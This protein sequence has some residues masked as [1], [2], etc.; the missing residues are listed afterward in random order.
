MDRNTFGIYKIT[1]TANGKVYIG[2]TTTSFSQRWLQ[3][4]SNLRCNS[5]CNPQLQADWN[6]FGE[7]SFLFE[8]L[9]Q[10]KDKETIYQYEQS[11]INRYDA[12]GQELYNVIHCVSAYQGSG[13]T[14][15]VVLADAAEDAYN[16]IKDQFPFAADSLLIR[17]ALIVASQASSEELHHACIEAQSIRPGRPKNG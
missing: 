13:I 9:E 5:H 6:D 15:Q 2:G 17:A 1:N 10:R 16:K 12:E 3:H 11:C 4:R 14:K 7:D 8:I